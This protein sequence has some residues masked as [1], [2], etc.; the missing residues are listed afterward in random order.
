VEVQGDPLRRHLGRHPLDQPAGL[1]RGAG[2]D[3]V[4]ERDLVAAH[5]EQG[6][7]D[8]RDGVRGDLPLV[9][10]AQHAGDVAAHP[11]AGV[12]GL[13]HDRREAAEALLDGAVD[14]APGEALRRGAEHRDLAHPAGEGTIQALQVRHQHGVA[15]VRPGAQP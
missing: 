11:E 2:A 8:P 1:E 6:G 9:G 7:G 10:A 4:A 5:G 14:V 12:A 15:D 13:L 3:R